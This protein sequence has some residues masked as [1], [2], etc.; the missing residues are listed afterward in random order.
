MYTDCPGCTRQFRVR[1]EQIAAAAGQVRCGFCGLQFDV[2]A[3][4]RDAPLPVM[5]AAEPEFDLPP[6]G[7]APQPVRGDLPPQL[8]AAEPGRPAAGLAWRAAALLLV[9]VAA[10]QLAWQQRDLLQE[11]YPAARP[12]LERLCAGIGCRLGEFRDLAA[13]RVVNRDVRLHPLYQDAL[14]VNA[15]IQNGAARAQPWPQVQLVLY[16]TAGRVLAYRNFAPGEYLDREIDPAR[17]M[18]AQSSAHFTLELSGA[19][20]GAVSF[21]FGFL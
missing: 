4:L 14:L 20:A 21:E 13:I 5:P 9:L 12:W 11:R 15:T 10:L 16:D 6:P 2:L 17:G 3:R 7:G 8:A 19:T 18:G 1:A